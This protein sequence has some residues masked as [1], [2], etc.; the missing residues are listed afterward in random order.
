MLTVAGAGTG[1]IQQLTVGVFEKLKTA[2][3]VLAFGRIGESFS[4]IRS[5]IVSIQRVEDVLKYIPS[6][7]QDLLLLASGDPCFFGIIEILKRNQVK[8]DE[9][10]PG[11]SSMQY[12]ASRLKLSWHDATFLSFHGRELKSDFD[13]KKYFILTDRVNNANVISEYFHS[14]GCRGKIF[15]GYQLSYPDELIVERAIGERIPVF[16][17]PCVVV[18]LN[19]NIER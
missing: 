14:G 17:K 6:D 1:D 13:S 15:A 19:E 5:D 3:R 4:N 8:I 9:V 10:C 7:E 16:D 2:D 11:V 18:I 12:L